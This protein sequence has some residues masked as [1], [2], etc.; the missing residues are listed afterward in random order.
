[1]ELKIEL[2]LELKLESTICNKCSHPD[3]QLFGELNSSIQ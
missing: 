1:M 2:D 3:W